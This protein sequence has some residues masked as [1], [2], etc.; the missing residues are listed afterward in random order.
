MTGAPLSEEDLH[1][2]YL[3]VDD[4]PLSR[5]KRNIARDFSDGY[6]VAEIMKH[7]FPAIVEL[8][9]FPP[10]NST[11]QK[12]DNWETLNAKVFRK[13]HFD[14]SQ[15]EIKEITAAV[16]G[17]IERFLKALQTKITQIKQKQANQPS[18]SARRTDS[19][20]GSSA[21][22]YVPGRGAGGRSAHPS[23]EELLREKDQTIQ[24]LRESIVILT[25]KVSKLEEIIRVKDQKITAFEQR[26][27]A[28]PTGRSNR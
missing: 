25:E 12:L 1:S 6:C 10:A 26:L 28:A 8:H 24:E 16:P 23:A 11:R 14:V 13:L 3:W 17:A 20:R 9:N 5:P 4:I 18:V 2:L 15:E 7:F 27:G 19:A 21:R 22:D